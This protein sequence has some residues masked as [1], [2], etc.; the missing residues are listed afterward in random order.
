MPWQRIW[1]WTGL[2][3][4]T[5][6]TLFPD[7]VLEILVVLRAHVLEQ[8]R[9]GLQ[10]QRQRHHPRTRVRLRIIDGDLDVHMAEV[11][12]TES[13][14][15]AEILRRRMAEVVEPHVLDEAGRADDEVVALPF[16]DRIPEPRR[17]RIL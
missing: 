11:F 13:L 12:A 17:V 14:G 8:F 15:H 6:Y 5:S 9:I 4:P 16:A 7:E 1:S 10:R 2:R 3:C